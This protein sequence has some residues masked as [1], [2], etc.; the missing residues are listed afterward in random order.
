V[1]PQDA[2][3]RL[4]RLAVNLEREIV[5][6]ETEILAG[7][8]SLARVASGGS[9]TIW[10]LAKEDHP[11]ATRH[12][13]PKRDPRIVN[14]QTGDFLAAWHTEGPQ[15]QGGELASVLYNTDPKAGTYL[16]GGTK[17][18][19]ARRPH[20]LVAVQIEPQRTVRL[21]NAVAEAFRKS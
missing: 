17:L 21:A 20:E 13:K 8:L 2:A 5:Q 16:E 12:R 9:L 10:H 11:Y 18:M 19:F 4:D 14:V 15:F 6:A 3:D 7:A 1:T